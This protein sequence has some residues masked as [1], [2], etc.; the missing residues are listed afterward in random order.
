MEWAF[1]YMMVILKIPIVALAYIVW[2]AI[3]QH[4]PIEPASDD[5]GPGVSEGPHRSRRGG[6]RGP[7][8]GPHGGRMP[9]SP[10]RVRTARAWARARRVER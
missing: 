3:R 10:P 1:L 4:E 2:W 6:P 8:R 9:P 5:G 7:R